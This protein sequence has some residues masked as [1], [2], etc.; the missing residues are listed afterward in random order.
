MRCVKV[1]C[2]ADKRVTEQDVIELASSAIRVERG[3]F[4]F[5][6]E[7]EGGKTLHTCGSTRY[8]QVLLLVCWCILMSKS[9]F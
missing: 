9:C 3:I 6:F 1:V 8:C 4:F 2:N 7:L 5:V